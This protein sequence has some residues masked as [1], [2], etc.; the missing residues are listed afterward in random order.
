MAKENKE[1]L[2]EEKAPEKEPEPKPKKE[3]KKDDRQVVY[4]ANGPMFKEADGTL[5][6]K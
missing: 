2:V 3:E 5:S 1:K 4:T 6:V